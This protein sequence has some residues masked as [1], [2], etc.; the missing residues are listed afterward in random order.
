M[1]YSFDP[2]TGL[3]ILTPTLIDGGLNLW[4]SPTDLTHWVE[5][6][7]GSSTINRESSEIHKVEGA[8]SCRLDI[9]AEASGAYVAQ[10]FSMIPLKKHN[11][12]H[13]YKNSLA[14]KTV[15][16][17]ISDIGENVWLTEN[18]SWIGSYSIVLPNSL[19]WKK[20]EVDFYAHKDYSNY[21]VQLRQ[22]S[23]A[24]SSIYFDDVR[25]EEFVVDDGKTLMVSSVI[26]IP[27]NADGD[28]LIL[29][30]YNGNKFVDIKGLVNE[31]NRIPF[32]KPR[33]LNGLKISTIDS[34]KAYVYLAQ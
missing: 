8:F 26:F 2:K 28:R 34:G 30:D 33:K 14:D 32:R 10:N 5:S 23:A 4:T 11:L 27:T 7:Y 31:P 17:V 19:V 1:G 6:L 3:Y 18:G 12:I 9:D 21:K 25:I 24:S 20:F 22:I 15:G 16:I 29:T 13:W